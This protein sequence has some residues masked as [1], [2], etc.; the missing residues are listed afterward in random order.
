[1]TLISISNE[2]FQRLEAY[3][4][5]EFLMVWKRGDPQTLHFDSLKFKNKDAKKLH[6]MMITVMST[7]PRLMVS[8]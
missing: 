5:N 2:L 4:G 1:M 7:K 8:L 6:D 3:Y